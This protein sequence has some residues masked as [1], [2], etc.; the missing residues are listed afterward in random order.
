MPCWFR[1]Y[2]PWNECPLILVVLLRI[3]FQNIGLIMILSYSTPRFSVS[4]SRCGNSKFFCYAGTSSLISEL[5]LFSTSGCAVAL[6]LSNAI[7]LVM[8]FNINI[9][10]CSPSPFI[11][12]N[13]LF[14]NSWNL[15][16]QMSTWKSLSIF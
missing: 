14:I 10:S 8:F 7:K 2:P 15:R 9:D 6:C 1:R 13:C 5:C 4:I 16:V 12:V 11:S 3:L